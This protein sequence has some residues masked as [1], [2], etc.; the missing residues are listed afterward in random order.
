MSE[1]NSKAVHCIGDESHFMP[2]G[3]DLAA[4]AAGGAITAMENVLDG[5]VR[6]AY[7]LCRCASGQCHD[8][9]LLSECCKDGTWVHSVLAC[10]QPGQA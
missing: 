6:N 5:S 9:L 1:D 4:L 8:S 3:Y 2:G 7:A 10:L